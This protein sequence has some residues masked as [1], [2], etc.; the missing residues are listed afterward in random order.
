MPRRGRLLPDSWQVAPL[1]IHP[2]ILL[3]FYFSLPIT[4]SSKALVQCLCAEP[5]CKSIEIQMFIRSCQTLGRNKQTLS[6]ESQ[7]DTNKDDCKTK[8][9]IFSVEVS[10]KVRV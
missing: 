4:L 7:R 2:G 3:L 10:E 8:I 9:K 1:L 5:A 6:V